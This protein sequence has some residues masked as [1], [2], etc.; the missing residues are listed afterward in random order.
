[1]GHNPM[2]IPLL[3]DLVDGEDFLALGHNPMNIPLL[4]DLVDGGDFSKT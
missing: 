4:N 2:N 3:N 1:M